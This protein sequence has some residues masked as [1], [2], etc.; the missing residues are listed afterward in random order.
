MEQQDEQFLHHFKVRAYFNNVHII[1]AD[2]YPKRI[3]YKPFKWQYPI[4]WQTQGTRQ[5]AKQKSLLSFICLKL[6][7]YMP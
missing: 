5:K 1:F 4:I 2:F 3:F 6:T 7:T